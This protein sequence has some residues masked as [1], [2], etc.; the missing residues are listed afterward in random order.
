MCPKL[1]YQ[2]QKQPVSTPDQ[3]LFASKGNLQ[4]PSV[5]TISYRK[6]AFVYM[7]T[8]KGTKTLNDIQKEKKV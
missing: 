6:N 2:F 8:Q 3:T 4:I 1:V 5:Q 7:V